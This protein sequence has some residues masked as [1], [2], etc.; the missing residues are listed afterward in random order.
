[1]NYIIPIPG[2]DNPLFYVLL[3]LVVL[4]FAAYA[5]KAVFTRDAIAQRQVTSVV[6]RVGS[7]LG[8]FVLLA[9][10]LLLSR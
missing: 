10:V 8:F 9:A 7:V 2:P 1:M 3:L 5:M 4:A 6:L